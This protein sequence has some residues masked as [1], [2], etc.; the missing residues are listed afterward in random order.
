MLE[1]KTKDLVIAAVITLIFYMLNQQQQW[2]MLSDLQFGL[3]F[4]AIVLVLSLGLVETFD[5]VEDTKAAVKS[6]AEKINLVDN[7]LVMENKGDTN[8]QAEV[9]C[10]STPFKVI[11]TQYGDRGLLAGYNEFVEPYFQGGLNQ[12]VPD[13]PIYVECMDPSKGG[14]VSSEEG[15][16]KKPVPVTP[17]K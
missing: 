7:P 1:I 13:H 6:V 4:V 17:E 11:K 3:V 14:I 12:E 5:V 2:F 10:Y 8:G 15:V 9:P 16:T